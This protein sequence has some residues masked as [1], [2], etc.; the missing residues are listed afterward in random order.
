MHRHLWKIAPLSVTLLVGCTAL[1]TGG[2][3]PGAVNPSTLNAVNNL[4]GQFGFSLKTV[5]PNTGTA[6]TLSQSDVTTV[7]D[8]SG[9]PVQYSFNSNNQMVF[10]PN[11]AGQ[12]NI[13]VTLQDGTVQQFQV[14]GQQASDPNA[15]PQ[16]GEVGFVPDASGQDFSAQVAVGGTVDVAGQFQQQHQQAISNRVTVTFGGTGISGL[17]ANTIQAVYF[18]RQKLPPFAYS[19]DATGD[20]QLDPQTFFL[21]QRYSKDNGGLPPVTVAYNNGSTLTVVVA[22]LLALPNLPT[23]TPPTPG[24]PAPPPPPP[25]QFTGGQFIDTTIVSTD[26]PTN[27][28]TFESANNIFVKLP[29]PGK[30]IPAPLPP[31]QDPFVK[32]LNQYAVT[33]PGLLPGT[34]QTAVKGVWVGRFARPGAVLN[35]GATGDISVDPN[36][37]FEVRAYQTLVYKD[38]TNTQ[39]PWVRVAYANGQGQVVVAKF[40]FRAS[41]LNEQVNGQ[42]WWPLSFAP[43]LPSNFPPVATSSFQAYR[44]RFFF[45]GA[46]GGFP[47]GQPGQPGQGGQAQPGGPVF[48]QPNIGRPATP[49][50][51]APPPFLPPPVSTLPQGVVV[52]AADIQVGNPETVANNGD[53]GAYN[54]ALQTSAETN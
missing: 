54:N 48:G 33:I 14:N 19:V 32:K 38:T 30:A 41:V 3:S 29:T 1:Q 20:L 31:G 35:V 21:A 43:Q 37:I 49:P 50:V 22:N 16:T 26:T 11:K 27:L 51:G 15:A 46:G 9:N 12:Q 8:D 36:L 10:R 39:F 52:N 18:D 2:L 34:A 47:G 40:R 24:Q 5:D 17:T 13:R 42:A 28:A 44:S 45:P 4:L 23:F 7:T 25:G 53:L 6:K